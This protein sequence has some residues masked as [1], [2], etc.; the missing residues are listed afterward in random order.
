[1]RTTGRPRFRRYSSVARG[2]MLIEAGMRCLAKGGITAFTIDNICLEAAASRGLVAH[3]FGSKDGLLA[4][5]YAEM[6]DRFTTAL[7]LD[8]SDA[9]KICA[10]VESSF[11]PEVF[12]PDSLRIW[13]ALWGEIA[14]NAELRTVHRA[15]YRDLLD[16][17]AAAVAAEAGQRGHDVDADAV[18][19]M[20]VAL[21]D[22]LWLENGIDPTMLSLTA[23]K[24]ACYRF[25]ET[26]LGALPRVDCT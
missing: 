14:N 18:A 10:L 15:R 20:F 17:V 7:Q 1:M 24:E 8:R 11:A 9:P 4:A 21:S 6:Y 3:H 22:G 19:I 25:L 26:H 13:L 2:A 5:V 12:N 16:T 23:A